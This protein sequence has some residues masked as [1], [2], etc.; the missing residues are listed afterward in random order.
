MGTII[1]IKQARDARESRLTDERGPDLILEAWLDHE[2]Q[3]I[4]S[5]LKGTSRVPTDTGDQKLNAAYLALAAARQGAVILSEMEEGDAWMAEPIMHAALMRGGF[6][7]TRPNTFWRVESRT[8]LRQRLKCAW[9]V[10]RQ[11]WGINSAMLANVRD[12]VVRPGRL[13]DLEVE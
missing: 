6:Y 8:P 5:C 4:A 11:L 2:G 12:L 13:R 7:C 10:L 3:I 9:W 1:D